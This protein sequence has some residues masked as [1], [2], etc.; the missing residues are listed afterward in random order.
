[1]EEGRWMMLSEAKSRSAGEDLSDESGSCRRR[2][3]EKQFNAKKRK[4]I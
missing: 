3:M 4:R 1:M 2:R